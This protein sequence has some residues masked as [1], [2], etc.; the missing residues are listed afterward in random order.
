[1]LSFVAALLHTSS[2]ERPTEREL[3]ERTKTVFASCD[4]DND[5]KLTKQDIYNYLIECRVNISHHAQDKIFRSLS[6]GSAYLT[7]SQLLQASCRESVLGSI[8]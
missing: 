2:Q 3:E 8:V 6:G 5:G 1:M 4:A 7:L